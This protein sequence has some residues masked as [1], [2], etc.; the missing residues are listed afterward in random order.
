[1]W[2]RR[3]G[4][5]EVCEE[6][7]KPAEP[8]CL[9][10]FPTWVCW[11]DVAEF[12]R[13]DLRPWCQHTGAVRC[14]ARY[15]WGLAVA[16]RLPNRPHFGSGVGVPFWYTAAVSSGGRWWVTPPAAQHG[17]GEI[18][19]IPPVAPRQQRDWPERG[20]FTAATVL[21]MLLCERLTH[22]M[23]QYFILMLDSVVAVCHLVE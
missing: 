1:M 15:L 3:A 11:Q 10:L 16:N 12:R 22:R 4:D 21:G 13:L 6:V 8:V 14:S 19:G 9:C 17:P 7:N 5:D 2:R 23:M 20:E 18:R